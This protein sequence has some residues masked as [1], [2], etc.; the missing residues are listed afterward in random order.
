MSQLTLFVTQIVLVAGLFSFHFFFA[1][2]N[3]WY[4]H[5][6]WLDV[7]MHFLGGLWAGLAVTWGLRFLGF[8]ASFMMVYAGVLLIGVAWEVYEYLVGIQ[9][10]ANYAFDTSLDLVMDSI[11]GIMGFFAA[12]LREH[13]TMIPD[14]QN[15]N[16]PS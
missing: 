10:E 9:R 12:R 14:A 2:P 3:D 4:W 8:R 15:Q 13:G 6:V 16:D 7:P 5:Y 1:L 11:G